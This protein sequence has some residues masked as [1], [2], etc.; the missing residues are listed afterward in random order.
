MEGE[1]SFVLTF[2]YV[3]GY[4][5]YKYLASEFICCHESDEDARH[6]NSQSNKKFARFM[7]CKKNEFVYLE[8][9][10]NPI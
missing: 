6:T 10:L 3:V 9:E 4:K 7:F 2:C 8:D 5:K 1:E